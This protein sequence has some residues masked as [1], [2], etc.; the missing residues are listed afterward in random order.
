M[1]DP[2]FTE[3]FNVDNS[4]DGIR[5]LDFFDVVLCTE[6]RS[7]KLGIWRDSLC[8]DGYRD[9]DGGQWFEFDNGGNQH[10]IAGSTFLGSP[11]AILLCRMLKGKGER[12]LASSSS[13]RL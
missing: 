7:V 13:M 3:I 10:L 2:E 5:P 8:L 9:E 4:A 11:V 1:A 6:C 12:I